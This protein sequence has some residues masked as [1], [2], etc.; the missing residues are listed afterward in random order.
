MGTAADVADWAQDHPI[1]EQ[2]FLDPGTITPESW[3]ELGSLLRSMWLAVLFVVL[4]ASN[5]LVGHNMIPSFIASGHIGE[6]WRKARL[7]FYGG[8]VASLVVAAI[9]IGRAADF[10]GVLRNF[11]PDYW[12]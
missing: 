1:M 2:I 9:F 12:I 4:F 8:A 6:N 5:M 3:R 10:A 7:V 11:W